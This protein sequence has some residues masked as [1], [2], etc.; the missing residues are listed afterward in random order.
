MARRIAY[1]NT[2]DSAVDTFTVA[3]VRSSL[4]FA[5]PFSGFAMSESTFSEGPGVS[6]EESL[7][8][9]ALRRLEAEQRRWQALSIASSS[10]RLRTYVPKLDDGNPFRSDQQLR[11]KF[12]LHQLN[13]V[14]RWSN[15]C[16]SSCVCLCLL[17]L[18]VFASVVWR[19][20]CVWLLT[21]F[22]PYTWRVPRRTPVCT[23]RRT[24]ARKAH[25]ANTAR[26]A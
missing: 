19:C 21:M 11:D 3:V 2:N 5:S 15:S 16:A 1:A 13:T 18:R 8:P 14:R 7:G 23:C 22:L 10:L 9:A 25:G 17:C 24:T 20:R 6:E 12:E 4:V 26:L